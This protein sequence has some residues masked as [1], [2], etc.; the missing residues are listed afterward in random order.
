MTDTNQWEYTVFSLG[1]IWRGPKE[2]ELEVMLNELGLEGWE[3]VG[4]YVITDK[5]TLIAKRPLTASTR[6]MRSLPR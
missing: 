4:T 3:V 2:D 1:N 6:R 5:V